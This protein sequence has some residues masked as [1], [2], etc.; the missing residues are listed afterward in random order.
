MLFRSVWREFDSPEHVSPEQDSRSAVL[1]WTR[2]IG[3][4]VLVIAGLAVVVLATNRSFGGLS[5][6]LLAVGATLL[7]VVLLTVP[8]WMRMLRTVNAERAARIRTAERDEIAAHLHDSVLQT[9]ALIQKQ[10]NRPDEVA[11]LAR[12]Q[13]RELRRWLF[14]ERER[15]GSSLAAALQIV[16]GDVEDSYGIEVDVVTVG[17]L[18]WPRGATAPDVAESKRWAALIGATREALINAADRKSVV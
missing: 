2:V 10:A 11:R 4:G 1:T 7:G 15:S 8:L 12:G 13:E 6:T 5:A 18:A 17:D 9:L 14:G 16:A 3:G